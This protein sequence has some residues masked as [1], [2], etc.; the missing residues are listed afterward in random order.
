MMRQATKW[1]GG[2]VGLLTLTCSVTPD[3]VQLQSCY[4]GLLVL[5]DC[6][7]CRLITC[8]FSPKCAIITI[9]VTVI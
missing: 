7:N 9:V 4:G 1:L 3:E 8:L 2:S 5:H 6:F